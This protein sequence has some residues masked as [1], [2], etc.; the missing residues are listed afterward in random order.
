MNAEKLSRRE[1]FRGL[2]LATAGVT[3]AACLPTAPREAAERQRGQPSPPTPQTAPAAL[4]PVEIWVFVPQSGCPA[5]S[6]PA[7]NE[8]VRRVIREATGVNVN[9]YLS[10]STASQ[11]E[12][13]NVLL[14]AES[15]PLDL[16]EGNWPDFRSVIQ[17]LDSALKQYGQNIVR[18]NSEHSW[19]RMRDW[20]GV[21]WGYPR[22]GPMAMTHFPFFRSDW[23]Q[24]LGLKLPETW[25]QMETIIAAFRKRY[26]QSVVAANGRTNLMMNTLGAFVD[27]GC[28]NWLDPADKQVKPVETHPGYRDWIVRMHEWQRQGWWQRE[29]FAN[30]DFRVMLK[31]LTIGVWLGWYSRITVWW[32][33]IRVDAKYQREDYDLCAKLVGPQGLAR[34]NHTGGAEAYMVPR[35]SKNPAAV[36]R[37]VDWIYQGLPDDPTHLATA[38]LGIEGEDWE[39]LDQ[40]KG[41]VRSRVPAGAKCEDV[42][43]TDF[44]NARGMGTELYLLGVGSDG[45]VSRQGH[46]VRTYAQKFDTGK[47]AMD[48]DVPYDTTLI[49]KQFPGLADFDRLLE[50]ESIKFITAVRPLAEW[51]K[52]QR[53]I[54]AAGLAEWSR[55][56]TQQYK[57]YHA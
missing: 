11:M 30:P 13:L 10:P 57:R 50:E 24:D 48:Y 38:Q 46:H 19:K 44:N 45:K 18:M 56:H 1:M 25:D 37:Y 53:E 17:P 33:G 21:T 34:T 47:W 12:K 43:G 6:N 41:S 9:I 20:D 28:G 7:K 26:P 49:Q 51:D 35:K 29:T 55:Y 5:G 54:T 40:G 32:E 27:T 22:F 2:G 36:I 42:Y 4:S 14:A 23:L 31:T 39:W 15:Q 8:A 16:F 3:L 52:F